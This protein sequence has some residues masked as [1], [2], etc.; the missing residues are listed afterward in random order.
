ME[1]NAEREPWFGLEQEY[2]FLDSD[3]RPYGW[4]SGGFP[5]PYV[6]LNITT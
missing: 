2:T 6:S 3:G 1:A 4:P 5:A